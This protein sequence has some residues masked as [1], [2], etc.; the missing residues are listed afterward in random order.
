MT[1]SRINLSVGMILPQLT[2]LSAAM[3]W[4]AGFIV[5]KIGMESSGPFA[6]VALR[7]G[8][9]A[10]F[11]GI[12]FRVYLTRLT[13]REIVGGLF[14]ALFGTF[15][16]V[17]VAYALQ[18]EPSARVVFLAAL[19]VPLVPLLQWYLFKLN[20]GMNVWFG[21]ALAISGVGV[22]AGIA[23]TTADLSTGD[24]FALASAGFI[25][26]QVSILSRFSRDV[27]TVHLAWTSLAFTSLVAAISSILIGE[28][29][30]I[31]N[32]TLFWIIAGFGVSTA[33]IQFAMGWGQ[34]RMDAS[35][36][37]I[38]Y[39]TEPVF[40]GLVGWIAGEAL[41]TADVTGA[42]L[43]GVGVIIGAMPGTT[44]HRHRFIAARNW[45]AVRIGLGRR[46]GEHNIE[47]P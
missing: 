9:A 22:M 14:V 38:I 32:P 34:A 15:G 43:I 46:V 28:T 16:S 35:K 24:G 12:L 41:G 13:R 36:A 39:A 21:V 29:A 27:N 33:Y 45:V 8:A 26:I 31:V 6:F 2:L 25:A 40:G 23:G 10:L 18:T 1:L 20:P 7:F 37:S 47:I 11:L 4:G 17:C 30:P 44:R 5:T 19:Y 42:L 3:L